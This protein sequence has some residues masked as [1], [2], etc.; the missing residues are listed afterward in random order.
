MTPTYRPQ[1]QIPT[2]TDASHC[3]RCG[4]IR[5]EAFPR[6][7]KS[8]ETFTIGAV[9]KGVVMQ[10]TCMAVPIRR[11]ALRRRVVSSATRRTRS[12]PAADGHP[13]RGERRVAHLRGAPTT[14]R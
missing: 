9:L 1:L 7:T 10:I 6:F 3:S 2:L 11:E 5:C 4:R 12:I 8:L 13:A 14:P